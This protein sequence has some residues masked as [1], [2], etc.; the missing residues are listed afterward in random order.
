MTNDQITQ[1]LAE[2][3]QHL[4]EM[5]LAGLDLIAT[6]IAADEARLQHQ[7]SLLNPIDPEAEAIAVRL[8]VINAYQKRLDKLQKD[9]TRLQ[10]RQIPKVKFIDSLKALNA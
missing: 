10:T 5:E 2:Q 3:Q 8:L 7:H 9:A 4:A 6:L 1:V